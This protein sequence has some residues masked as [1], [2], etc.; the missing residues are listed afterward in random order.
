MSRRK[1]PHLLSV[2]FLVSGC[3]TIPTKQLDALAQTTRELS[4]N[5]QVT[6]ARIEQLAARYTVNV[7]NPDQPISS[8]TFQPVSTMTGESYDISE[9]LRIRELALKTVSDYAALLKTFGEGSSTAEIDKA[10]TEL[11]GSLKTLG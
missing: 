2:I 1:W 3:A 6:D 5:V 7:A 9:D 8:A 10:S 4:S 11:A